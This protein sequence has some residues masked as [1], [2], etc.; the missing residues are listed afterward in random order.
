MPSIRENKVQ[1]S[2][3]EWPQGG[4]E[5]SQAWRGTPYLWWGVIYPR[6]FGCLPVET[7]LEIGPGFGRF[8]RYLRESCRTIVLVDVTERCI[9][10]CRARFG[11]AARVRYYVND[12]KSLAMIDDESVDFVFSFDSL[13]HAEANVLEAYLLQL[14]RKLKSGGFG[15]VHHS[16]VAALRDPATGALP[17]QNQHWRAES[18]SA[19]LFNTFCER[20]SL[21]CLAQELVNW[22]CGHLTDCFSLFTR[23]PSA[24]APARRV[25]ENPRFMDEA[26]SLAAVA[27]L[28][29]SLQRGPDPGGPSERPGD[30]GKSSRRWYERVWPSAIRWGKTQ[31]EP[32]R[33]RSTDGAR[34]S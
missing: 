13:V 34:W 21:L 26:Q 22:G 33:A 24:S 15:F 8:T 17:F 31:G 7:L 23:T 32:E 2:T 3:Y 19:D 4:D 1:W 16:N 20:A 29:G 11:E 25:R 30:G 6:I 18:M 10:A 9:S 5:W 14:G 27:D 28:Y 12:G